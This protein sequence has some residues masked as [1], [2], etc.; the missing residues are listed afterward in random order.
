[1]QLKAMIATPFQSYK[2][3]D[4]KDFLFYSGLAQGLYKLKY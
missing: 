4:T 2:Y 1:M 3:S